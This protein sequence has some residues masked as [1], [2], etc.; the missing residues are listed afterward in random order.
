[1]RRRLTLFTGMLRTRVKSS[2]IESLGYDRATH[3]L[4]VEFRSGRIYHYFLVPR[5]TYEAL[6]EAESIGEYFN[7]NVRP[8][9]PCR[10]V[11]D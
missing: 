6:S 3:V 1:M 4:E 7:K 11:T 5:A 9:Y 10:E 2:V 8:V